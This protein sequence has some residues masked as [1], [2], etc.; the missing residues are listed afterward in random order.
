LNGRKGTYEDVLDPFTIQ[1]GCFVLHFPSLEI[2]PGEGIEVDL[3]K[4]VEATIRRLG[5]NDEGTCLK[6]R[7]RYIEVYCKNEIAFFHLQHEAPFIA[8][9]LERQGLR[10][11]IR[12]IMQFD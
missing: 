2:R 7:F 6:S 3:R 10:D 12:D 4:Q 1:N 11:G 8:M 9:E 5:L